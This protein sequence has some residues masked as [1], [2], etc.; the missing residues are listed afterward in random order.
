MRTVRNKVFRT[1]DCQLGGSEKEGRGHPP[2]FYAHRIDYMQIQ[3]KIMLILFMYIIFMI[4][5]DLLL[6]KNGSSV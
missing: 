4:I 5:L 6:T 1:A 3:D 2:F